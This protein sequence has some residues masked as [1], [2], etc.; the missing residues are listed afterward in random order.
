MIYFILIFS[1]LLEGAFSNIVPKDS[2][3]IPL[4]F[5]TSISLLY[6]YFKSKKVNFFITCFIC[7]IFYDIIFCNS[8]FINA[9]SF[10]LCGGVII[11]GYNYLTYN[12]ISSNFIN[13]IALIM[14]RTI[15]YAILC[16][17]S[18]ASFD[19]ISLLEAIY[20]SLLAN[21]IYGIFIYLIISILSKIF[22]IK[23]NS[24]NR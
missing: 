24:K 2:I 15:T 1:F 13:I 22:K 5:L 16:I 8:E 19:V 4:F 7:G 18:F 10:T 11:L 21:I 9:L 20:S 3:F 17:L 14:Y 6:P 12:I 23:M